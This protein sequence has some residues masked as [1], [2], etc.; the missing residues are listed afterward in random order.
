MYRNAFA[1]KMRALMFTAVFALCS[2]SK[3]ASAADTVI[4]I[5]LVY[6]N[7]ATTWV[8]NNGGMATF[9]AD[10]VNRM[11]QA[12]LNSGITLTFRL[13]HS[14]GVNYTTTSSSTTPL[15]NDLYALQ[16]GVAPFDTVLAARNTYGADVVAMLVDH[17]S[18][19]GY[20]G[21]GYALDSWSG[22]ADYAFTVNA[23]QS[24]AISHTLTH[25]VGHNLGAHHSKYQTQDPGPNT[26]LDNQYSAGWY[27][28][29]TNGVK[30]HTIMG[31]NLDGYGNRYYPAPMFS[32][33]L[34][35]YMGTPAGN[36]L[37]GDNAR[38]IRQT[39]GPV[40]AY[41]S[42]V[43]ASP[44]SYSL[45]VSKSG[46]GTVTSSP[47]GISCGSTC[48]AN[49]STGATITL[50]PSTTGGN[51]FS[52]WGGA[53]T[54]SG[55]CTVTMNS[56]KSVSASFLA[57]TGSTI[58]AL[59]QTGLANAT[60][61][62][63]YFSVTVPAGASNLVIQTSGGTGDVDLYVRTGSN[64]TLSLYDCRP[65]APGNTESCTAPSP[66]AGTYYIMLFSYSAYSGVNLTATYSG[67]PLSAPVCTLTASPAAVS[68]NGAS[69]LTASCTNSPT[70]YSWTGGTCTGTTAAT[71]TVTP[72]ATTTYGVTGTNSAGSGAA[73]AT[74]TA[75]SID[76][77][78]I[79]MLLLD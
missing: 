59:S 57:S 44:S 36:A 67:A 39:M 31:Y 17:G 60:G 33:P 14:M 10:V 43:V 64:P 47:T 19:Y 22:T 6:D 54:G 28:T 12:T 52:G 2:W 32:T 4:D 3:F 51:T 53:C 1:Q 13:V 35:P 46:T 55:A 78:P 26:Y 56:D 68:R 58:T 69:V 9:S 42:T 45:A 65:Y 72:M 61:S 11:N 23:V 38:L 37:N 18:A 71:C 29:G 21:T 40:A 50:T 73:S 76:L 30:Y 62:Y 15:S 7:T 63:Q 27:F 49:F 77:T 34:L 25:E 75:A 8:N 79:L 48:L 5:M 74:V 70:S 24:V 20:V 66:Q 41:R 16:S